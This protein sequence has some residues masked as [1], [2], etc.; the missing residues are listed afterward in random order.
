LVVPRIDEIKILNEN[1]SVVY[2]G[3]TESKKANSDKN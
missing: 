1:S 3:M 2:R